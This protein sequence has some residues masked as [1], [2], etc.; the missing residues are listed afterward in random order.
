MLK[1]TFCGKEATSFSTFFRDR[2]VCSKCF[3]IS[4]FVSARYHENWY[5]VPKKSRPCKHCNFGP[6]LHTA[7][8]AESV[9]DNGNEFFL[10]KYEDGSYYMICIGEDPPN[11]EIP[12]N[13]CPW[14]GRYL[15]T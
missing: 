6:I 7:V 5:F 10:Q 11:Y 4:V 2:P 15:H 14:C 1:C 13:Y 9:C 3:G 12:V 8:D